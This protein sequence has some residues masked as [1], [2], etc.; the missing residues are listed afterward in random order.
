MKTYIIIN[1]I[2]NKIIETVD[3]IQVNSIYGIYQNRGKAFWECKVVN[4]KIMEEKQSKN[5]K[6]FKSYI[7]KEID[8]EKNSIITTYTLED[9]NTMFD[10]NNEKYKIPVFYNTQSIDSYLYE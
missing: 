10:L 4:L 1:N 9:R 3:D 6:L 8:L 2:E 7:I 5:P